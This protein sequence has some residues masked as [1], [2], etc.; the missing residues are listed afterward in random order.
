MRVIAG[1]ARGHT[2][3]APKGLKTRP[4]LDRV[5]EA[6]FNVLATRTLDAVVLD[7]FSGSGAIGIEALSRGA[8]SCLF[9]DLSKE[10][11]QVIKENLIHT[12]LETKAVVFNMEANQLLTMLQADPKA[13]FDLVFLDPPYE[14]GQYESIL[15]KLAAGKL[16]KKGALVIAESNTKLELKGQYGFLRMIKQSRYGDT[17][18]SYY[19]YLEE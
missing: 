16:L 18:V 2:L 11:V 7:L 9:T 8:A 1:T 15:T 3:K 14:S 13:T 17:L 12:K 4:T 19:E 10:A 5:R 6:V